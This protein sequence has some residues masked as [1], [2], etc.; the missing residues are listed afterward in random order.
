MKGY[1]EG[2]ITRLIGVNLLLVET[3]YFYALFIKDQLQTV[4]KYKTTN[5]ML[6]LL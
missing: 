1:S 3:Q 5:N 6:I 4:N 2:N